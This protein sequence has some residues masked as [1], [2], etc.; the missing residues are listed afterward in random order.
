MTCP[1]SNHLIALTRTLDTLFDSE[2]NILKAIHVFHRLRGD[3]GRYRSSIAK[4]K[5]LEQLYFLSKVFEEKAGLL[6]Y[7]R[8]LRQ[9]EGSTPWGCDFGHWNRLLYSG[10]AHDFLSDVHLT[11]FFD[12][13]IYV[14]Q[15][16]ENGVDVNLQTHTRHT[17]L[18]MAA[19]GDSAKAAAVLLE[20]GANPNGLDIS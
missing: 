3:Q 10:G 5:D 18:T 1:E 9:L 7:S 13:D 19:R 8:L 15:A 14:K 4:S 16:L 20:A 17:L 2:R 12:F 11:A 6:Q